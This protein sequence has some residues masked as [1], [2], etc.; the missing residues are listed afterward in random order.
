MNTQD[1]IKREDLVCAHTY[2]PLPVVLCKGKGVWVWDME[3]NKYLDMMTA[4]SAITFG[5]CNERLTKTLM[6]Q[7]QKLAVISRA[8]YSDQLA[9][10]L[11][12]VCALSGLEKGIV[13]NSGA[14]AVESAL[15]V[16][17][18]WGYEIKGIPEDQAEIIV[19]KNNFHGRTT[20]IISFSSEPL[21]KKDFGP[22]TPGFKEIPFG[23]A[24]ALRDAITPNTCAF[25]VEPIQG[26][27][28]IIVP[29]EGWLKEVRR[30]CT[31][32]NVLLILDEVQSGLGRTGKMFAFQ[33]E[34]IM[35][36]GLILGKAL[37]GGILPLSLFLSRKEILSLM[38][39]G[40]HGSTFGG[41]PLACAVGYEA[42]CL[43]EAEHLDE[44]SAK[45]GA[46]LKEQFENLQSPLI[47]E[48]RGLG[49]WIGVEFHKHYVSAREICEKMLLNGVLSKDTHETVVRFAP[50]LTIT[51]EEL[52]FAIGAFRKTVQEMEKEK[53]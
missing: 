33:H 21:Y 52:D 22:F 25:L 13:M 10:F 49:L 30:I 40:S 2:D 51:Q 36:D 26:E 24:L 27:A 45:L 28:G 46:Y 14:E 35:P 19:A 15:K 29:S 53:L 1:Y 4:Y 32:K 39:P 17:R 6:D 48:V 8:F 20:T 34:N 41:N 31:E 37:G 5:H 16:A 47:K 42:L 3:G 12:K 44:Q 38:G 23:D 50:P 43:L 18:R 7:A 9:P 11:E